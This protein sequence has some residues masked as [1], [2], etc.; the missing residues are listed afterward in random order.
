MLCSFSL[1]I[2]V[3]ANKPV[4]ATLRARHHGARIDIKRDDCARRDRIA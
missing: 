3:L 2:T 4:V 1:W